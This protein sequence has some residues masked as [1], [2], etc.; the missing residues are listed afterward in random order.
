[1]NKE[2]DH[3]LDVARQAARSGAEEIKDIYR[4]YLSG[5]SI[6]IREKGVDDPV[7]AA[8]MASN[9]IITHTLREA[10]PKH[11]I[12]TEEE[13]DTW[14]QTGHEWVWMI[15]PLDGT[16]D[17][18]KANG[19][20]VTMVGVTHDAEPVVG[21]VIE[22]TTGQELYA[23]KGMGAYKSF[24]SAREK[25]SKLTASH[26]PDLKGLRIAVSR[27]HRDSK[28]DELIRLLD[29]QAEISSGSVGRKM[30]LVINGEVDLYVHPA[31]GTK[32]WDTCAC[33]VIASEAGLVFLSGTGEPIQYLRP[34]GD[35]EN[36]YGLLVCSPAIADKVVWASRKVW[37]LE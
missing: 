5:G 18:I 13:P 1:M 16:R 33:E 24:V 14:G 15:D 31:R 8:D 29:V 21:V 3:L 22:P 6:R 32:L 7:T 12:L 35:L 4:N 30:A 25:S 37:G 9:R 20:F 27:S 17:F 11:A 10:F 19:E 26:A 28:V 2:Q 34:T 23:V 36:R